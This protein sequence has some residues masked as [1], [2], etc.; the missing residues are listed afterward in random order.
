MP[1]VFICIVGILAL[2]NCG[3]QNT[4]HQPLIIRYI[5][6]SG[7]PAPGGIILLSVNVDA[8]Q[9]ANLYY[10]WGATNGFSIATDSHNMTVA[11]SSPYTYGD[12]GNATVTVTYAGSS[13]PFTKETT[14]LDTQTSTGPIK[15]Q[16]NAP[17]PKYMQNLEQTGLSGVDTSSTTGTLRWKHQIGIACGSPTIDA[18]GTIYIICADNGILYALNSTGG[19]KWTYSTG[20]NISS[21]IRGT[22]LQNGYAAENF[23][24]PVAA[25]GE[26]GTIYVSG[27]STNNGGEMLY[28]LNQD[29]TLKWTYQ[30][31]ALYSLIHPSLTGVYPAIPSSP[32]IGTDGTIYVVISRDLS[33]DLLAIN[34][35]GTLKM[36]LNSFDIP[37]Y[38]YTAPAIDTNGILYGTQLAGIESATDPD[39][40]PEWRSAPRGEL[41]GLASPP[42]IGTS[43]CTYFSVYGGGIE[44]SSL[45]SINSNGDEQWNY[46]DSDITET[47]LTAPAIGPD[48]TIY[49][50]TA[51]GLFYA[52]NP[53]GTLK[54]IYVTF[55]PIQS[56]PAIGADGTIYVGS[57]DGKLF[58][59]KST[60]FPRWTYQTGGAIYSSSPAIGADGTIY[61][62]STDGY[63]Y[64]IY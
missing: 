38:P 20:W 18:S 15:L 3:K 27:Y 33:G 57:T 31:G 58:A 19:L 37:L 23:I 64:A 59:F 60:G 34:S 41:F 7:V 43:G 54:W 22:G 10:T 35:N 2:I 8:P 6:E 39:G 42:A 4:Q 30:I 56:S 51:S 29:G 25:I 21:N 50:G 5:T 53:D 11:I 13:S 48:G 45:L 44:Y 61:I 28:A 12:A 63:L 46:Y 40:T 47:T 16:T 14:K 49:F 52:I 17:W 62:A 24:F 1:K 26:D 32:T 9:G 55:V 36:Y